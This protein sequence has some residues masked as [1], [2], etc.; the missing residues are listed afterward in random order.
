MSLKTKY[1]VRGWLKFAAEDTWEE[2]EMTETQTTAGHD[3]HFVG[4]TV[5]ELLMQLK[6]FTP[7][8]PPDDAVTLDSCDEPGRIDICGYETA[9]GDEPTPAQ[10][11]LWKKGEYRLWAVTYVF[12]VERVTRERVT[13]TKGK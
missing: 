10:M 1:E 4:N 7:F 6:G 9:D 11:E 13:L 12:Q 3:Y 5:K 2:G 8:D